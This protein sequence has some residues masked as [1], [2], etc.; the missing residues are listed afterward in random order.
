MVVR[1]LLLTSRYDEIEGGW[2][3]SKEIALRLRKAGYDIS[4]ISPRLYGSKKHEIIDG[5]EVFRANGF[6]VPQIPLF[7]PNLSSLFSVWKSV[8]KKK[9]DLVYDVTLLL[10]PNSILTN[11][12]FQFSRTSVPW[13]VHVCGEFKDLG[14]SR[15]ANYFLNSI[16]D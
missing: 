1:V 5:I 8:L 15:M 7:L 3:F 6:L 4:V 11:V 14:R 10:H 2:T 9:I 13:I 12:L 16:S